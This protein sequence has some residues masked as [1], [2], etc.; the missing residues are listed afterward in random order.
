MSKTKEPKDYFT[1]IFK[2][3]EGIV[4]TWYYEKDHLNLN[5][6]KVIIDY[7]KDYTSLE[8]DRKLSNK[9]IPKTKRRFINPETG[10][11]VSYQRAKTLGI[12][13]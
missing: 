4:S 13:K 9:K 10:K 8:E 12:T 2:T 1:R 7:P 3:K 5:P 11:E 6:F